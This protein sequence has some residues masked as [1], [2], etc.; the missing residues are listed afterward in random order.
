MKLLL[1]TFLFLSLLFKISRADDSC[2]MIVSDVKQ[3]NSLIAEEVQKV[4][5]QAIDIYLDRLGNYSE[6][7][8]NICVKN[9]IIDQKSYGFRALTSINEKNFLYQG[10][11]NFRVL[12]PTL[13]RDIQKDEIIRS[14][15]ITLIDFPSNKV[16]GNIIT[17]KSHI[18]GKSAKINIK[19]GKTIYYREL[20]TPTAIRKNE[21]INVLYN[22]NGLVIK[23]SG[24]ALENGAVNDVI[25]V[26]NNRSGIVISAIV[27][28][29]KTA[30]LQ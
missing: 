27:Q 28:D 26:K 3:L 8:S 19:N 6:D 17:E 11:F 14:E 9:I 12:L 18:I 7:T 30:V 20:Y 25:K 21:L 10:R 1:L 4:F 24:I 5:P 2:L 16:H 22:R 29:N 13:T 15:D 23:M